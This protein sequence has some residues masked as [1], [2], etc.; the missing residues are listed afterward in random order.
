MIDSEPTITLDELIEYLGIEEQVLNQRLMDNH[1]KEVASLLSKC[2]DTDIPLLKLSKRD[3]SSESTILRSLQ[4]W[5]RKYLFRATYKRL[6]EELLS[7]GNAELA[8][9]VCNIISSK[10]N[11]ITQ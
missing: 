3:F 1:L 7:C 9:E 6:V 5:K 11:R 8:E 4:A 10:S 2:E